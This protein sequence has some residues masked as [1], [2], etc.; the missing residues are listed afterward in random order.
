M[1][2][3]IG[4]GPTTPPMSRPTKK[5]VRIL[6]SFPLAGPIGADP[7]FEPIKSCLRAVKT[8][9]GRCAAAVGAEPSGAEERSSALDEPRIQ[10]LNDEPP[11]FL[12]SVLNFIKKW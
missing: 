6:F 7:V 11:P 1:A 3:S 10:R 2:E 8:C 5:S 4:S 12:E 9:C